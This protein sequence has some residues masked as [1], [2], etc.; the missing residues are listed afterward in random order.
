MDYLHNSVKNALEYLNRS[1][2]RFLGYYK[3]N[4]DVYNKRRSMELWDMDYTI[5]VNLKEEALSLLERL[6]GK[7]M[8]LSEMV[9][10]YIN[11]KE[12]NSFF[13]QVKVDNNRNPK[14]ATSPIM[15]DYFHFV[16][17]TNSGDTIQE[18]GCI[19]KKNL[20]LGFNLDDEGD[21]F[22][23][24][25]SANLSVVGG[26]KWMVDY[27]EAE[28]NG[29]AITVNNVNGKHGF[30]QIFVIGVKK[31][32]DF[33]LTALTNNEIF[34]NLI[35]CHNYTNESM[36]F[37]PK[38][39]PTNIVDSQTCMVNDIV[40]GK[41]INE[42]RYVYEVETSRQ[43]LKREQSSNT[44]NIE[45]S[46]FENLEKNSKNSGASL[47]S[48]LT[49]NSS[50]SSKIIG[51]DTQEILIRKKA[52]HILLE[53]IIDDYDMVLNKG[54]KDF[55]V[56]HLSARGHYSNFV[57]DNRPY[58]ILD[59][60]DYTSFNDNIIQAKKRESATTREIYNIFSQWNKYYAQWKIISEEKVIDASKLTNGD[61]SCKD[62][63]FMAGQT[64]YSVSHYKRLVLSDALQKYWAESN[65]GSSTGKV[66]KYNSC[67]YFPR[68]PFDIKPE[69]YDLTKLE[70]A[71]QENIEE[72]ADNKSQ[73][74]VLVS[75]FLDLFTHRVDAW[76]SSVLHYVKE[77]KSSSLPPVIGAYG[78][79]F[80][81]K[82]NE[83]AEITNTYEIAKRMGIENL[84]NGD[85]LYTKVGYDKDEYIVTPSLKHAVT[86]AILRSAYLKTR[87]GDAESLMCVNLS[88]MRTRQALRIIDGI[89]SGI[90]TTMI[91]G[92]D[93]ERYLHE[94]YKTTDCNMSQYI[95]PLRKLF[96]QEDE[97][98]ALDERAN[99][100]EIE[101]INA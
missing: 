25:S 90:P 14:F 83:R 65:E 97:I 91:L 55:I 31:P 30:K 15:P 47:A 101:T 58:G 5:V 79:L 32:C 24:D 74:R 4:S 23:L 29:M 9:D 18:T 8:S 72:L 34:S 98:H 61:E 27:Q 75:E 64:P 49:I 76:L 71:L 99:T 92:A 54:I 42:L 16:G 10:E 7:K 43:P 36:R 33:K 40:K 53:Q 59:V 48:L 67:F 12:I 37:I 3:Q 62:Y 80:N 60:T 66:G 17:I 51:A 21:T 20:P 44:E 52:Y 26:M 45:L 13:P 22:T 69:E 1:L 73:V 6:S 94:A 46:V 56:N 41:D 86:A 28:K 77:N 11:D 96:P 50:L 78:M 57:I 2:D 19:V 100:V 85:K 95:Y 84:L 93:M 39:V 68:H 38:G 87:D 35:Q 70:T 88:S 81:L 89:R 63:L 82:E